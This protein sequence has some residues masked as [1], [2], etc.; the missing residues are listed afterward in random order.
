MNSEKLIKR[1]NNMRT[2]FFTIWLIGLF[3]NNPVKSWK[4]Q[5]NFCGVI[6]GIIV[7]EIKGNPIKNIKINLFYDLNLIDSVYSDN[8]GEFI[9]GNLDTT[10]KY[11]LSINENGF[12]NKTIKNIPPSCKGIDLKFE[13]K[14]G[15][16]TTD[17]K[18]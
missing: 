18:W 10:K 6:N 7:E 14:K 8:Q 1:K 2:A 9:F 16:F 12:Q 3:F 4:Y 5:P 17:C 15:K 11:S 13:L